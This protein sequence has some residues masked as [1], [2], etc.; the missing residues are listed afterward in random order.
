MVTEAISG[1]LE[2]GEFV[3]DEAFGLQIPTSVKDVP[4]DVLNP[5]DT[6][7]DKDAY[8]KKANEL[9][10]SFRE[11]FKKFGNESADFAEKGGF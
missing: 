3:T 10:G 11:N 1:N 9:I 4:S 7:S 5:R 2:K 8:D 6:W